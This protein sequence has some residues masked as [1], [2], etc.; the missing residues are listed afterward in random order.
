MSNF[1]ETAIS[2]GE[3]LAKEMRNLSYAIENVVEN[4]KKNNITSQNEQLNTNS[5]CH[6]CRKHDREVAFRPC[7]DL[8]LCREC[9]SQNIEVCPKCNKKIESKIIINFS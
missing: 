9:L 3:N 2:F 7:G 4:C 8:V 6:I 5:L 1:L